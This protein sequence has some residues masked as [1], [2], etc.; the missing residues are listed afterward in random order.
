MTGGDDATTADIAEST[1]KKYVTDAEKTKLSNLSGINT[2]DQIVPANTTGTGG[3]FFSAYNSTTG[4]FTKTALTKNDVGL[5]NVDNIQQIPMSYLDTDGALTANSDT[6]VASQKAVKTYADQLIASANAL[7]YKGTIDCSTNPNYPSADA[8]F[9]YIVSV[10]GKI[11]GASGI[12]VEVGDMCICNTDGTASGN[13]ATVGTKWNIIE[14]N[15]VGAVTGPASA[16]D[17]RVAFFDGVTGKII[18]D[19]GLTLSGS[20]TGDQTLAGLGGLA[21][22]GSTTGATIQEQTFTK[23][24]I[25][26][27]VDQTLVSANDGT[28]FNEG[29]GTIPTGW[30][31]VDAPVSASLSTRPGYWTITGSSANPTWKY[32]KQLSSTFSGSY[33]A[34]TFQDVIFRDAGSSFTADQTYYFSLIA[35]NGSGTPDE[36]KYNRVCVLYNATLKVWLIRGEVSDGTNTYVSEYQAMSVPITF[37]MDFRVVIRAD[38]NSQKR[39]YFSTSKMSFSLLQDKTVTIAWNQAWVQVEHSRGTGI[40]SYLFLGG[41]DRSTDP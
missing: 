38:L 24:I 6:K 36:T 7:V 13:Q 8:G 15:I 9:L 5:G 1:D 29:T 4:A 32:R 33:N 31:E 37:P 27:A 17:N 10:A 16:V 3:Q 23:S 22:D 35:D 25:V 11:G 39:T 2:G 19:S 34:I 12:N 20:N 14:K 26:P 21:L 40:D 18:K 28:Y 41:I 30:V